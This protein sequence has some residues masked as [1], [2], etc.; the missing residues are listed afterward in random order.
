MSDNTKIRFV[1]IRGR[2]VPIRPKKDKHL[3][4][5]GAALITSGAA[6]SFIT[7]KI[8]GKALKKAE[9]E[10]L[11]SFRFIKE[12]TDFLPKRFRGSPSFGFGR[13]R[14]RLRF[15]RGSR[16]LGQLIGGALISQGL[17]KGLGSFGISANSLEANIATE[18]GSQ[19]AAAIIA[20]QVDRK[21]KIPTKF[22]V[23]K[24]VKSFGKLIAKRFI[25][26]KFRVKF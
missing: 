4:I 2:I 13:A 9:R 10:S 19:A 22:S 15:A 18:V 23:P 21:L 3:K 12:Q 7:G 6:L 8:T 5:K 17:Q 20:R 24:G 16:L 1:R 14:T 26:R 25:A 11:A